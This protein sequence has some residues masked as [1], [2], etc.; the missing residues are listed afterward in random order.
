MYL[1][2]ADKVIGCQEKWEEL[3]EI[4]LIFQRWVA[5][6]EALWFQERDLQ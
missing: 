5:S 1:T 6:P 2:K 3:P 4:G